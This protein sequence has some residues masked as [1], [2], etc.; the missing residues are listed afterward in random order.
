MRLFLFVAHLVSI[1]SF[2]SIRRTQ[3][4][5]WVKS[6]V[7]K[8]CTK[9]A[10]GVEYCQEQ[11]TAG[12]DEVIDV[13]YLTP[14]LPNGCRK[15]Q[16]VKKDSTLLLHHVGQWASA[17]SSNFQPFFQHE[18]FTVANATKLGV[19]TLSTWDLAVTGLCEGEK[20]Q[21]TL[22]PSLGF[23]ASNARLPRP[24][25]VPSGATLRFDVE[26][27]KVLFVAPDGH[28]YR[29]CFF[30]LIDAD[31][32]GDLD[33]LELARHFARVKQPM[34]PHVM[35]EDSDG[36]GRISFDEFTGPKIP[37]EAHEQMALKEEL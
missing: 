21:I 11:G 7:L 26:V 23:D 3:I 20:V 30:S 10:P 15:S 32:S 9:L 17:P 6:E 2:I 29:P 1:S 4:D 24:S 13:R 33:E 5:G 12:L 27:I 19:D 35:Q 25:E 16:R 36:D 8:D 31:G 28:P 37:R 22:P 14:A 34:P 18:D